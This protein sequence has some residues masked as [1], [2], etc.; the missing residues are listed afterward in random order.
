MNTLPLL[1]GLIFLAAFGLGY[2]ARQQQWGEVMVAGAQAW[3]RSPK[4]ALTAWRVRRQLP[5]LTVDLRFADYERLSS[6]R[7]R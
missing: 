6:A 4:A 3:A 1:L 7:E 2:L 5:T